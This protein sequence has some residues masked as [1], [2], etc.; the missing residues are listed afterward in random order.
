[1]VTTKALVG[2]NLYLV[3]KRIGAIHTVPMYI[4][5]R[6]C[7]Y[8]QVRAACR[9]H[10]FVGFQVSSL[11]SQRTIDQG[12]AFQEA[13]EHRNES[14]LVIVPSQT[15]LLAHGHDD[16]RARVLCCEPVESL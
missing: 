3:H 2:F 12:A 7:T 1:M 4:T 5:N 8:S 14:P 13:V 15:K 11:G 9:Q 6:Y 16:R 10:D